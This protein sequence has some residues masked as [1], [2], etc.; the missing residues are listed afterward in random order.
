LNELADKAMSLRR[1]SFIDRSRQPLGPKR[2]KPSAEDTEE[3][4]AKQCL[5]HEELMDLKEKM[6]ARDQQDIVTRDVQSNL[7]LKHG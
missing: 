7:L 2:Q 1:G 5:L 6:P 3:L 4:Q